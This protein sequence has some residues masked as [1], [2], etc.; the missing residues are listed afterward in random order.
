MST[1]TLLLVFINPLIQNIHNPNNR[2]NL[3]EIGFSPSSGT[4][5]TLAK[6]FGIASNIL[7]FTT[8][9]PQNFTFQIISQHNKT[10]TWIYMKRASGISSNLIK[11]LLYS[12]KSVFIPTHTKGIIQ[13]QN[14]Q[15]LFI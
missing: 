4:C 9:I 1:K 14:S 10:F 2:I 12:V 5:F 8:F 3:K 6:V 11:K 15:F 13:I 7:T